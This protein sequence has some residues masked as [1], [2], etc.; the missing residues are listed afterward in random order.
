MLVFITAFKNTFH[1]LIFQLPV[2]SSPF[3]LQTVLTEELE[4]TS[5]NK[6]NSSTSSI[7]TGHASM[8]MLKTHCCTDS[9]PELLLLPVHKDKH[10]AASYHT[11]VCH[12]V[13]GDH[14][15]IS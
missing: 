11:P 1:S 8:S 2:H 7:T 15:L 13:F 4:L 3:K 14:P 9:A 6:S 12:T 10:N 5:H